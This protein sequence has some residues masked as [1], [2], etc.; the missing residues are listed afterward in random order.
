M[1]LYLKRYVIYAI[2]CISF[3]AYLPLLLLVFYFKLFKLYY[4][5]LGILMFFLM[6]FVFFYS[7]QH[8]QT[9]KTFNVDITNY[10]RSQDTLNIDILI[11][12]YCPII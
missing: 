7:A 3:Y 12:E 1:L 2:L 11:Q 6:Y 9:W 4:V 5:C 10:N 8:N